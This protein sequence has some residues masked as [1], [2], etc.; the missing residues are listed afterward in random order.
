M[1][2]TTTTAIR[3][4]LRRPATSLAEVR[5]SQPAALSQIRS[6]RYSTNA[7]GPSKTNKSA[8]EPKQ[9]GSANPEI[10][11]FSFEALGVGRNMKIF[12]IICLSIFGTMETWFYCKWIYRWWYGDQAQK[13]SEA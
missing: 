2:R 5:V 10:P 8:P 3:T 9:N 12:L 1:L 11:A 4:Q 13:S 7:T 6:L